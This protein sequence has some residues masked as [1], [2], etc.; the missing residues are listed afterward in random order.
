MYEL[1]KFNRGFEPMVLVLFLRHSNL[2]I[3]VVLLVDV[4]RQTILEVGFRFSLP[5]FF[6]LA[7]LSTHALARTLV[8]RTEF[9]LVVF[10][11]TCLGSRLIH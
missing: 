2:L 6:L 5:Q 9:T 7:F 3:S 8:V 4:L 11:P 1:L 10:R